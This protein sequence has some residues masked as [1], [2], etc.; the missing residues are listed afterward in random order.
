MNLIVSLHIGLTG[1][2]DL[3]QDIAHVPAHH[4]L[5]SADIHIPVPALI[6]GVGA[7]LAPG[8]VLALPITGTLVTGEN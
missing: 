3:L 2:P 7:V 1:L 5:G 8:H 6:L 4:L